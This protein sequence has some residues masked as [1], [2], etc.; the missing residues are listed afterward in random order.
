VYVICYEREFQS[1]PFAYVITFLRTCNVFSLQVVRKSPLL[2]EHGPIE[3]GCGLAVHEGMHTLKLDYTKAGW[4]SG[5]P[6][7]LLRYG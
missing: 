5:T 1:R 2:R 4:V 3:D 7:L 6:E